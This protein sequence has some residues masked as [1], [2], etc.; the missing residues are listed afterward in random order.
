MD[1]AFCPDSTSSSK[2]PQKEYYVCIFVYADFG[3]WRE[4]RPVRVYSSHI[5]GVKI[6]VYWQKYLSAEREN[7]EMN[8]AREN[9]TLESLAAQISLP[10]LSRLNK[11]FSKKKN[12]KEKI[13]TP[14]GLVGGKMKAVP[15]VPP[16]MCSN[17]MLFI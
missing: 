6:V 17:V 15:A 2:I 11:L 1:L 7:V 5:I 13:E 3:Y 4:L 12:K 16:L 9:Y 8:L 10:L 14:S